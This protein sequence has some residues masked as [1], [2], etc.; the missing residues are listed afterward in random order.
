M[1]TVGS[2]LSIDLRVWGVKAFRVSD[3]DKDT[4][5]AMSISRAPRPSPPPESLPL[6]QA[7]GLARSYGSVVAV[8]D[9]SLSVSRGEVWGLLGPNGAGKSTTLRMLVGYQ[10]PSRGR[11]RLAGFDTFRQGIQAKSRLGYLPEN[12]RLYGEMTAAAYLAYTGR[13][14]GLGGRRLEASVGTAVEEWNLG[15]V[16]HR[17]VGNLSRGFRQRVGLAQVTLADPEVLILD[18]PT[19]GLDPN[20]ATE[21]RENLRRRSGRSAILI[22]THLLSEATALCSHLTILH[23]GRVV[24]QGATEDLAGG[25]P[26]EDILRAAVRGGPRIGDL[27]RA[28]GLDVDSKAGVW[29]LA[30][31]LEERSREALLQ[32]IVKEGGELLE[33]SAGKRPLEEVF[34][35]LTREEGR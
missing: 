24:A 3:R 30:G 17:P 27:A 26:G 31:R 22:S 35:H 18:E 8:Q 20:Q 1:E 19:T 16:L 10:V 7:E 14:K 28:R 25:P 13:L 29:H 9:V 5:L 32:E 23:R 4:L 6:I 33:W 15:E 34:R 11:V 21:L 12:P 2:S